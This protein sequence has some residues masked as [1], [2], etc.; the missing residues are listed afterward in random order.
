MCLGIAGAGGPS[1]REQFSRLLDDVA[2]GRNGRGSG[3]GRSVI[4]VHTLEVGWG[5]EV[6]AGGAEG[7]EL[8]DRD[9]WVW[10]RGGRFGVC[11][12]GRSGREYRDEVVPFEAGC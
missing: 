8:L 10:R 9:L 7:G 3:V 12:P 11:V 5:K 6:A 4:G 2:L 1:V